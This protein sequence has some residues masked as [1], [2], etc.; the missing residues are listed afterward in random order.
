LNA[1]FYNMAALKGNYN[2]GNIFFKIIH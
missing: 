2:K 1:F